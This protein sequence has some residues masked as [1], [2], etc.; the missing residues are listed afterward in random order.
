ME[1]GLQLI[2]P[3]VSAVACYDGRQPAILSDISDMLAIFIGGKVLRVGG[4]KDGHRS[5]PNRHSR[6]PITFTPMQRPC[7][8]R[9]R[10]N[11]ETSEIVGTPLFAEL[12]AGND[13]DGSQAYQTSNFWR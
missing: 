4:A 10:H 5:G 3:Y 7:G 2:K 9:S 8:R 6:K 11:L 1:D 12:S 13:R